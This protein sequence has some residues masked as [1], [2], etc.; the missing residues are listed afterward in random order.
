MHRY[1]SL[2]VRRDWYERY[3]STVFCFVIKQFVKNQ[4]KQLMMVFEYATT[5]YHYSMNIQYYSIA[6]STTVR[7]SITFLPHY[8]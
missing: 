7:I 2:L 4:F 6:Y 5:E 1:F 8:H 3:A